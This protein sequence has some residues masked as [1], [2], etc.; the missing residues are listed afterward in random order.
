MLQRF[1]ILILFVTIF[2]V[3]SAFFVSAVGITPALWIVSLVFMFLFALPSFRSLLQANRRSAIVTLSILSIVSLIIESFAIRTGFPY[4]A[5]YYQDVLG[6][7]ILGLAPLAVPLGWIPLVL[8]SY[9]II[10]AMKIP[11]RI[12]STALL[13]VLIDM[14]I[15]PGSFALG[16]WIWQKPGVYYGVP[17]QNFVGWFFSGMLGAWI[18]SA[19][20]GD[21][22]KKVKHRHMLISLVGIVSFWSGIAFFKALWIPLILGLVLSGLLIASVRAQNRQ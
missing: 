16:I 4:G 20:F 1:N 7:K 15:D 18:M 12:V 2:S 11:F 19:F 22:I 6:P 17:F 3:I 13:L 14:V 10:H 9:T 5:F 8:G 21:S